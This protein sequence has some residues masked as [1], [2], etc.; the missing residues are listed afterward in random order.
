MSPKLLTVVRSLA[1]VGLG[2]LAGAGGGIAAWK[3]M[4]PPPRPRP[5]VSGPPGGGSL[6]PPEEPPEG[7]EPAP[8]TVPEE[9]KPAVEVKPPDAA[10]AKP[11][12]RGPE[13]FGFHTGSAERAP[14]PRPEPKPEPAPA[15]RPEPKPA[16]HPT[17]AKLTFMKDRCVAGFDGKSTLHDFSGWTRSV[18]G[19]IEYEKGRLAE[20]AKA[21]CTIDAR[22]LDTG[23][24]DR[25]KEMHELHLESAK[26]PDMKFE[27]ASLKMT[28][29][30]AMDMKGSIEIHGVKK[31]IEI[32]CTLK[33]R[34]DGFVYVKG[35]IKARMTDFGIKPPSKM[36]MIN[37]EDEIRI[38]F[39][40]WAEPA[41]GGRK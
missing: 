37:V 28:G 38:W 5:D 10:P 34:R 25:D 17:M 22:K 24:A 16:P 7:I 18:T 35:E 32:A 14:E 30:E 21:A 41:K 11:P 4:N 12:D 33:V 1:L 27:L 39:E 19:S 36:G 40:V 15:P 8:A 31:E 23:D 29:E 20:T 26:F 2:T 9:V 3:K 13:F 6:A